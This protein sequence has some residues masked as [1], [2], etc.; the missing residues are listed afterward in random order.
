[1]EG[2]Q[3]PTP[4]TQ[5]VLW[6]SAEERDARARPTHEMESRAGPVKVA[7]PLSVGEPGKAVLSPESPEDPLKREVGDVMGIPGFAEAPN[8]HPHP[9]CNHEP[10]A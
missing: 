8:P 2:S 1:M 3:S 9:S 4:E 10:Q 6:K 7:S 5:E